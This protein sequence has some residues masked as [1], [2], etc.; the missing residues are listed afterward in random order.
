MKIRPWPLL[1]GESLY[2]PQGVKGFDEVTAPKKSRIRV[3]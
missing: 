3:K 2:F 1:S